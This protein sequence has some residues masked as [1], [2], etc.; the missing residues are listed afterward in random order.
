VPHIFG[1]ANRFPIGQRG[2]YAYW[3]NSSKVLSASAFVAMTGTT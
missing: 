3:R 2:L 1:A